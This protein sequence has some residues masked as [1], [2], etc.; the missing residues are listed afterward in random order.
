M[1][2]ETRVVTKN[3]KNNAEMLMRNAFPK[4]EHV[5]MWILLKGNKSED[6]S[7]LE[8]YE[9]DNFV[10]FTYIISNQDITFILF[11]AIDASMQS[12]GYG[13]KVLTYIRNLYPNNR[14]VLQMQSVDKTKE[15][16]EQR[17]KRQK[18]YFRNGYQNIGYKFDM[19]GEVNEVLVHG[20]ITVTKKEYYNMFKKLF[21]KV[22][23]IFLNP[24]FIDM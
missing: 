15:N 3:N 21:G 8:F 23:M 17:L 16:Y 4:N 10:G 11:L 2:L 9:N 6:I 22:I 20:D 14:M 5:P 19:H 13:S 12:Q 7:F 1:S 24:K 18:F